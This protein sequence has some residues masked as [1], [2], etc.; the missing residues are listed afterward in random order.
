MGTVSDVRAPIGSCRFTVRV[1]PEVV[2]EFEEPVVSASSTSSPATSAA[3]GRRAQIG[4]ALAT[5]A[6]GGFEL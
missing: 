6:I 3:P 2:D 1:R 4:D 5:A